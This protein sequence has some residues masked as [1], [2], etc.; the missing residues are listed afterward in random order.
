MSMTSSLSAIKPI[1]SVEEFFSDNPPITTQNPWKP[2][3]PH[4]LQESPCYPIIMRIQQRD[5][6]M[7]YRC[8]LHSKTRLHKPE[9]LKTT[10]AIKSREIPIRSLHLSE[11][12]HHCRFYKP[13]EHKAAISHANIDWKQ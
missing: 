6:L 9:G 1:I 11:I 4:T 3:P 5:G 12:E 7:Y 13:E 2:L 8:K 10:V